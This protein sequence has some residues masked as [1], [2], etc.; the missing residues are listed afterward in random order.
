MKR[1]VSLHDLDHI[2]VPSKSHLAE[3]RTF[4]PFFFPLDAL[5]HALIN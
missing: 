1:V 5:T 2:L 3:P 4:R